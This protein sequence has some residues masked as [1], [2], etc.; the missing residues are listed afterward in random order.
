MRNDET[1]MRWKESGCGGGGGG[2]GEKRTSEQ[3]L[4]IDRKGTAGMADGRGFFDADSSDGPV[5]RIEL[6][7]SRKRKYARSRLGPRLPTRKNRLLLQ[8]N[9]R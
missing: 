6:P 3:F 9:T 8:L 1:K 2:D 4:A 7:V 5:R